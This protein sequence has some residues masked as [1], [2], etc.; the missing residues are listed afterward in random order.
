MGLDNKL[1]RGLTEKAKENPKR[2][3]FA[4]ANDIKMLKAA[5][6][7]RAEGICIPVLLGNEETYHPYYGR[8]WNSARRS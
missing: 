1:I 2:V 5:Q 6:I 7:A 4:E 8:K 3:V